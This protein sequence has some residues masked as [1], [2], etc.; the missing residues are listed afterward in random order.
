[1]EADSD[2]HSQRLPAFRFRVNCAYFT[3]EQLRGPLLSVSECVAVC[4]FGIG[5]SQPFGEQCASLRSG[6]WYSVAEPGM[7]GRVD[8]KDEVGVSRF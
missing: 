5:Y 1:M 7:P 3:Q 8:I 2:E 6:L 4:R